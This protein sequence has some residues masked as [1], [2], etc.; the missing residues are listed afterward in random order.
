M[1][2][3]NT[4]N[5]VCI[6]RNTFK[7]WQIHSEHQSRQEAGETEEVSGGYRLETDGPFHFWF[8]GNYE[9]QKKANPF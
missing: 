5:S 7:K 3:L 2:E 6:M 4:D 9:K 8:S 1:Q